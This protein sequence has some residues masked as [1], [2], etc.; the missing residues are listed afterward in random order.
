MFSDQERVLLLVYGGVR[1][2]DEGESVRNRERRAVR[3]A[4]MPRVERGRRDDA[5]PDESENEK[6]SQHK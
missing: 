5:D 3:L 1:G 2:D 4:K 6:R